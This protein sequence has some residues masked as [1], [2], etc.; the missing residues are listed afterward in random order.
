[1]AYSREI[2]SIAENGSQIVRDVRFTTAEWLREAVFRE[3]G[4]VTGDRLASADENWR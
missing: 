3:L 1:M 2:E 4:Y